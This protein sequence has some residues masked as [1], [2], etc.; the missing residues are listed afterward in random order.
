MWLHQR[1]RG[2]GRTRA[3]HYQPELGNRRFNGPIDRDQPVH[4]MKP[5]AQRRCAH[6]S[7]LADPFLVR[8]VKL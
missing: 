6:T 7:G 3:V 1:E 2:T 4:A 8:G 5:A